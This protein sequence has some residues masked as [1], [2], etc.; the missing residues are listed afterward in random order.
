MVPLT[1]RGYFVIVYHSQS[2][3]C[4]KAAE[5]L[6]DMP[7]Q[8]INSMQGGSLLTATEACRCVQA[9]SAS[10]ALSLLHLAQSNSSNWTS[11]EHGDLTPLL[12]RAHLF[13]RLVLYDTAKQQMST[14]HVVDL[15]GSQSL[16]DSRADGQQ[17]QEKLAI[18][19]QLLSF[20][21]VVSE[22]SRLSSSTGGFSIQH[23]SLLADTCMIS[24][25][26]FCEPTAL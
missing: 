24:H 8:H 17:H 13:V 20:S 16:A 10:E 26:H 25:M 5:P 18:N 15:A 6:T 12:N 7:K 9:A 14:L 3:W 4:Q 23:G 21:N 1:N 11:D 22:L 2:L 19:Q